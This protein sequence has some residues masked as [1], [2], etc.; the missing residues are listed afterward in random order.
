LIDN[1]D[2]AALM[3]AIAAERLLLFCG[4]G[5][6]MAPP[7]LLP[8]ASDVANLCIDN[9]ESKSGT[10][11]PSE[12]RG[13][14]DLVTEHFAERDL[15]GK[16]FIKTLVPWSRLQSLNDNAGH[17]A[18]ADFCL[19]KLAVAAITTNYDPLIEESARRYGAD[20]VASLTG[21]D[22][23]T[24]LGYSPLLKLHGC[25]ARN[26]DKTIWAESQTID[27]ATIKATLEDATVWLTDVMRDK[28][29]VFIGFWSDWRYLNEILSKA[30]MSATPT[31]V[32]VVDIDK[33]STLEA[34]APALWAIAK[35]VRFRHIQISGVDFLEELRHRAAALFLRNQ[36]EQ[37]RALFSQEKHADPPITDLSLIDVEAL[38]DLRRDAAFVP[39]TQPATLRGPSY[40]EPYALCHLL[41]IGAGAQLEGATYVLATK[42]VRLI[43]GSGRSVTTLRGLIADEPP[44]PDAPDYI[45]CAGAFDYGT[46]VN[47]AREGKVNDIVR[48]QTTA[49]FLDFESA[50]TTL[51]F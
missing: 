15:L 3:A 32:F 13:R 16:Y 28:D 47:I 38:Y 29:I 11:L 33:S 51:G 8:S 17:R 37:G 10:Q 5:L 36:Y 46:P 27:D 24:T 39:R 9:D 21:T 19:T 4:A 49:S 50:R 43:N 25:L 7:T 41:L 31:S 40:S 22:A 18:V 35:S 23:R 42:R 26:R 45:I 34:K 48:R 1:E 44:L 12:M 2:A 14:L 20:F 30:I 6:S